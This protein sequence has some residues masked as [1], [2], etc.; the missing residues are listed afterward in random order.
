MTT[1][2]EELLQHVRFPVRSGPYQ[3]IRVGS[4]GTSS[5]LPVDG[6]QLEA[7]TA[8]ARIASGDTV[9]EVALSSTSDPDLDPPR[10][11]LWPAE[12]AR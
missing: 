7:G 4:D 3:Y 2:D 12:D 1:S 9:V 5:T 10:G 6:A 11:Q 8:E